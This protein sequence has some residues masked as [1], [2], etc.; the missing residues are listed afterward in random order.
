MLW[1]EKERS[2]DVR[3][4]TNFKSVITIDKNINITQLFIANDQL[5]DIKAKQPTKRHYFYRRNSQ[6]CY[7]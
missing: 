3:N 7:F 2:K 1:K 5:N 6:T 4:Q